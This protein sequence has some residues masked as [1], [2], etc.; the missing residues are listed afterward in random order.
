MPHR[1][2][3]FRLQFLLVLLAVLATLLVPARA[4]AAPNDPVVYEPLDFVLD[5]D[6]IEVSP[7]QVAPGDT[8]TVSIACQSRDVSAI[9]VYMSQSDPDSGIISFVLDDQDGDGV[10]TAERMIYE[11]AVGGEWVANNILVYTSDP[12][13][14]GPEIGIYNVEGEDQGEGFFNRDLSNCSF[15][16]D[17]DEGDTTP[18][19]VA[20]GSL[21]ASPKQATV[22]D[23]ITISI[24]AYD[25]Y[26]MTSNPSA[27]IEINYNGMSNPVRL[28]QSEPGVF[29]A[30]ITVAPGMREGLYQV[31]SIA[32]SDDAGNYETMW[33]SRSYDKSR[34]FSSGDFEIVDSPEIQGGFTVDFASATRTPDAATLQPGTKVTVSV[35]ITADAQITQA[36]LSFYA[37]YTWAPVTLTDAGDGTWT[38]SFVVPTRGSGNWWAGEISLTDVNGATY[39]TYTYEHT[40][41]D[42]FPSAE[43]LS[44]SVTPSGVEGY[45]ENLP[46]LDLEASTVTPNVTRRNG[47]VHYAISANDDSGIRNINLA[48]LAPGESVSNAGTYYLSSKDSDGRFGCNPYLGSATVGTWRVGYIEVVDIWGNK[49][50][51]KNSYYYPDDP[52]AIDMS[53][54]DLEMVDDND[55]LPPEVDAASATITP[56]SAT[57]GD[58]LT[59]SV[60]ATDVQE[61]SSV[62][63]YLVPLGKTL[64][65]RTVYLSKGS[66]DT[67]TGTY[68]VKEG[69]PSGGWQIGYVYASDVFG[70]SKYYYDQRHSGTNAVDF[71]GADFEV[72]GTPA[73]TTPPVVHSNSLSATPT[74]IAVGDKVTYRMRVTDDISGVDSVL[75]FIKN[76]SNSSMGFYLN[77]EGNSDWFSTSI[78][79]S[80]YSTFFQP[81]AVIG[82]RVIVRDFAGN[83]LNLYDS[84]YGYSSSSWILRNLSLLDV[85]VVDPDSST[86]IN[87]ATITINGGPYVY[88]GYSKRPAITVT[89]GDET[90]SPSTDFRVVYQDNTDAGSATVTINGIGS[91][92]GS[93]SRSFLIMPASITSKDIT[94]NQI[95]EQEY[96]G[97]PVQPELSVTH[98]YRSL[99]LGTD[100][101]VRYNDNDALGD[102]MLTIVGKGNYAGT[103]KLPFR[104][105]ENLD[106][107]VADVENALA[108]LPDAEDINRYDI[109][110]VNAAIDAYD[111]LSDEQK[112]QMSPWVADRVEELRHAV[113]RLDVV[114]M[115]RMYNQWTGEHFYTSSTAERDSLVNGGWAYESIGWWAPKKSSTPVYR[116]YNKWVPGGDHHYTM[117]KSEYDHLCSVGWTGEGIGWYSDDEQTI[118]VYREYNPWATTGTHNYTASRSEH[119]MLTSVGWR[120]EGIGWYGVEPGDELAV[121]PAVV[122]HLELRGIPTT[123]TAGAAPQLVGTASVSNGSSSAMKVVGNCWYHGSDSEPIGL[124]YNEDMHRQ[125]APA[126]YGAFPEAGEEVRLEVIT[127]SPGGYVVAPDC[128]VSVNGT[129]VGVLNIST[130][131]TPWGNM[132]FISLD[133]TATVTE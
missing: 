130:W 70:N 29:T 133:Y 116:L 73:D 14:S 58:E 6:D 36:R 112:G 82:V 80:Y 61:V 105:V 115:F 104:I 4:L 27:G 110:N 95:P 86:D 60:D 43:A 42:Q 75:V 97:A 16:V 5:L 33:D 31:R 59:I 79:T 1:H 103:I 45:E 24:E 51:F 107:A 67:W 128:V 122:T 99:V 118:P 109:D 120:D 26:G 28:S 57:I 40:H 119:D 20:Y 100:Y 77:R 41:A 71:S 3:Q 39:H 25:D 78:N 38:G 131:S 11:G 126:D 17:S 129:Q 88:D 89:L 92:R 81:G 15:V 123:V 96:A 47:S 121:P 8:V 83:E 106:P 48:L 117:D 90:L 35:P 34:D 93:A 63:A 2:A 113:Y 10:F 124:V 111:S 127:C 68:T 54:L 108:Y 74:R 18:P 13:G 84:R 32:A 55:G 62:R 132:T 66:G 94:P 53:S 9:Y 65:A 87:A 76:S 46:T 21:V 49:A 69:D 98:G 72:Y 7:K 91:Y 125:G 114:P 19:V 102:A 44:F 52:D 50:T 23:T 56:S 22:G 30:T 37:S 85:T 101:K 12:T 64:P